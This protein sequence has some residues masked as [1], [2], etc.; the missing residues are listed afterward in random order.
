MLTIGYWGE[1]SS[2]SHCLNESASHFSLI[3]G[4]G[5][6]SQPNGDGDDGD[7]DDGNGNDGD[8]DDRNGEDG[9]GEDGNG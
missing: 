7:G 4:I 9:N 3:V 5:V 2:N 8:S 1:Y 6:C